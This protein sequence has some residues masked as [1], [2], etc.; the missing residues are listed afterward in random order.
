M[1]KDKVKDYA[2]RSSKYIA[3]KFNPALTRITIDIGALAGIVY[4]ADK[5]PDMS[6]STVA[7]MGGAT[8]IGLFGLDRLV[9]RLL[10]GRDKRRKMD[11]R[12]QTAALSGII[13]ASGY[14]MA[15]NVRDIYQDIESM[16]T[17]V[18]KK[19]PANVDE[20]KAQEQAHGLPTV[21]RYVLPDFNSVKLAT[22]GTRMGDVQRTYRWK[23]VI[24]AVEKKYGIPQGVMAG[25]IMQESYGDPLQPN[26]GG[27]GGIG[28]VHTQG[29]TAKNLGLEIFG[30]SDSARDLQHGKQ[31]K[32][33]IDDCNSVLECV[34]A[35]DD[36]AHPLKNLDAIARYMMQGYRA[37]GSW[38]AAIQWVH[39]P[40]F[41]N[42][43]RGI[44][45]LTRVREH[46]DAYNTRI[47]EAESDFKSRN[48]KVDWNTY[49]GAFHRICKE[50]FGL[51]QYR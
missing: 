22:K 5:L 33:L 8:A 32:K 20:V 7:V 28:L 42:K 46:R 36:R 16:V 47:S 14:S 41:V 44:R 35:K 11:S 21:R 12:W 49:V 25:L 43:K 48:S 30:S 1:W 9:N 26:A 10:K 15:D 39:G 17:T 34:A 37:H 40:G 31:L 27:D 18:S 24:D 19:T 29:T 51:S 38:D 2:S 45:Y 13:V 23:P 6:P 4:A 3:K 50:N